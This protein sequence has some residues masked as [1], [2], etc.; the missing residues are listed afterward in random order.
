MASV[1]SIDFETRSAVDLRKA[2][3]YVYAQDSSTEILCMAYAFDDEEPELWEP[4]CGR[5]THYYNQCPERIGDHIQSGGEIRAWNAQFE[6]TIWHHILVPKFGFLEP[7]LDQWHCTAAEAAAMS[8]PRA[9]EQAAQVLGLKAQKDVEGYQLMMKMCKP[10]KPTKKDP[11]KWVDSP[12]QRARLGEYCKQDVRTERAVAARIRR[13][14]PT[15]RQVYL[16][17]QKINDRGVMV[18]LPLVE[19][20]QLIVA[21]GLRRANTELEEITGGEVAGVTKVAD[22]RMWAEAAGVELDNLRKDTVRDLL[23]GQGGALPEEVYRVLELR[24]EA[25]KTSN[26]KLDAMQ[27]ATCEDSR[28]RGLLLYHAAN[29]GRWGGKLIQPQ[30]F[31]RPTVKKPERFIGRVMK[32]EYDLIE[33]EAPA[34]AVISSLLRSMLI[35]E[36]GKTFFAGDFAQI[37]A[38]V[39]AWLFEQQDLVDL[40][41]SGGKVYETM[42]AYIFDKPVDEI[43]KDSFE[44]Q[45]GKNTVL[46]CGFQMG[47]KTFQRQA[48]V[49]A[50]LDLSD[51]VSKAGVNGYRELYGRIK[52]G[53]KDI[54]NAAISAVRHPGD[55]QKCGRGGCVK[56]VQRGKWLWCVLPAG[57]PL[58]YAL[59]QIEKH[60]VTPE[61]ET[62]EPFWAESVT[63]AAVDG[64][65]RKW[66][67]FAGYG[68]LWTN[69]VVQASARDLM[70]AAMLRLEAAG[71]PPVLSIHDEVISEREGGNLEEFIGIMRQVPS[72]AEGLPVAADGW[73]GQ[74]Y[75]K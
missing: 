25:G 74:R 20:A 49:Q 63:F 70:A 24:S 13:L 48:K 19:A 3:V 58:A 16:L 22:L 69:N 15:E 8:L 11:S 41:A 34:L 14:G 5:T 40:F 67:R 39:V 53:W 27:S 75:K 68:G 62:I 9:L 38:R 7:R 71:Y 29:T 45:V 59:P 51:E 17:D 10:R 31:A 30:N 42:A 32:N 2:G 50:G 66:K 46:G 23:A 35:A 57:R 33:M 64:L 4:V 37:E 1:L 61:D 21:E 60:L 36:P 56:F 55:I 6:R 12:E 47:W 18:D 54:N 28:S 72:W 44:R 26:A 52:Q 65:T 43:G 73:Q